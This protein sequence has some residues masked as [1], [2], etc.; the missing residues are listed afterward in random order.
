MQVQG[1]A[2]GRLAYLRT[3]RVYPAVLPRSEAAMTVI[4]ARWIR[5]KT[6]LSVLVR[7]AASLSIEFSLV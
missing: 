3:M 7:S 4:G 2:E 5:K 1:S 6:Y